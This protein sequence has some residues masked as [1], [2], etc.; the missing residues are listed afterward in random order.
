MAPEEMRF[1]AV[2]LRLLERREV[3]PDQMTRY[4]GATHGFSSSRKTFT[5]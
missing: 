4:F 3:I 2:A 5:I 1:D